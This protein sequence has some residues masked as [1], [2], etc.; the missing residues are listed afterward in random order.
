M[1]VVECVREVSGIRPVNWLGLYIGERLV[2]KEKIYG[3]QV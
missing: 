1:R 3:F 2:A